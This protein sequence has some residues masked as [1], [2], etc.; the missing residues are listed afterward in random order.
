MELGLKPRFQGGSTV[1]SINQCPISVV[2]DPDA[3]RDW[4]QEEK[5]TTE[6][7]MAGW[8]HW[9][10]GHESEWTLGIGDGQGGLA[11][12]DSWGRKE[13]D[14]TEWLIWSDLIWISVVTY[15]ISLLQLVEIH[16]HLNGNQ[17]SKNLCFARRLT[18]SKWHNQNSKAN[19]SFNTPSFSP[20][21]TLS[22][23]YGVSINGRHYF[24]ARSRCVS[25]VSVE[26]MH[27]KWREVNVT[28][29]CPTLCDPMDYTVHGILQ[30][31]I[32][33]WVAFPF[34]MRSFQPR[35]RTQVSHICRQILD[36]LSQEGSPKCMY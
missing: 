12:C 11:C 4:G 34:S 32:L 31:R 16:H 8:H 5:G 9:L 7:E 29:S 30:A 6:D 24:K 15:L 1:P 18:G 27:V 36:Q 26:W 13:S 28:Q 2:K 23:L 25:Y 20:L 22:V 35:D 19:L 10:D 21:S 3:G 17:G 33:E 14:M